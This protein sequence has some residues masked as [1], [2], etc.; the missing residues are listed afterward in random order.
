MGVAGNIPREFTGA[1]IW[2]AHGIT[3]NIGHGGDLVGDAVTCG[4]F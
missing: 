2:H 3:N 1:E 4:S